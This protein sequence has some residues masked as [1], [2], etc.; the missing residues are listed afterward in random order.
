LWLLTRPAKGALLLTV[1]WHILAITRYI[2]A[3]GLWPAMLFK[4]WDEVSIRL[5]VLLLPTLEILW[6]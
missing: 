1:L 2:P 5:D 3:L 6:T 4:T